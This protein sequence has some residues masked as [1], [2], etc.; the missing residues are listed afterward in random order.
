MARAKQP[1]EAIDLA[2]NV[3]ATHS[4]MGVDA[5]A[6]LMEH[7][8]KRMALEPGPSFARLASLKF[9]EAE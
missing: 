8:I 7:E 9:L 2:A 4:N 6:V 1:A 3:R 5:N